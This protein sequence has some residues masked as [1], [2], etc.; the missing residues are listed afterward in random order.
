M[1][2]VYLV[3]VYVTDVSSNSMSVFAT[4]GAYVTSFGKFGADKGNFNIPFN[5]CV[6]RDSF[7]LITDC[8]N[9]RVQIL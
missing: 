5:V 8:C 3:T 6:D 4:D 2:Y 1:V 7:V 9:N